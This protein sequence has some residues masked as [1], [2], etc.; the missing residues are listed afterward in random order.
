MV[1]PARRRYAVRLPRGGA[2]R[3]QSLP[4]MR[5]A[6][7]AF[8]ALAA[9]LAA[10]TRA[11]ST[12]EPVQPQIAAAA[13][14]LVGDDGAVLARGRA[15]EQRAIASI[16]KLMT[17]VVVLEHAHLG[18]VVRVGPRAAGIGES[19]VYLRSGEELTVAD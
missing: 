14:Y 16:T 15:S 5:R 8:V 17:S 12:A 18:D 6:L 7:V 1:T 2:P 3:L 13:W 4:L 19:T 11:A 9:V 10:P